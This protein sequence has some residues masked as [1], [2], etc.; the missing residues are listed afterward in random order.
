MSNADLARAGYEALNSRDLDT[1]LGGC[2]ADVELREFADHPDAGTFRGH[3][4]LRRW[5]RENVDDIADDARFEVEETIEN[6]DRVLV[7]VNFVARE[8][9]S[10]IELAQQIYHVHEYREGK[11]ARASG[12]RDEPAARRAAG[13]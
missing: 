5:V 6:G 12:Y 9:R 3:D 8:R 13:L 10:G 11:L 4:A 7:R 2:H 1:W